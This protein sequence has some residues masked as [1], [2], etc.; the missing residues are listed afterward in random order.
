MTRDAAREMH[1]KKGPHLGRS[2]SLA[3]HSPATMRRQATRAPTSRTPQP[4]ETQTT[5]SLDCVLLQ[6]LVLPCLQRNTHHIGIE[7]LTM[8]FFGVLMLGARIGGRHTKRM[9]LCESHCPLLLASRLLATMI[10]VLALWPRLADWLLVHHIP[11]FDGSS[12]L[13]L[14]VIR[15]LRSE[16]VLALG[17]AVLLLL[18][19]APQL[20]Q[21]AQ[22]QA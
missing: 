11:S 19:M 2:Q 6:A 7:L 14:L 20:F 5:P 16:A 4:V 1:A 21:V 10:W 13:L 8:V 9:V 12:L 3:H 18:D 22:K 15:S 17:H